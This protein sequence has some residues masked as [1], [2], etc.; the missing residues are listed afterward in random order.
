[1]KKVLL[2]SLIVTLSTLM[3]NAESKSS[4]SANITNFEQIQKIFKKKLRRKCS[5]TSVCL[6]QKHTREEWES[7]KK[8][9]LF[10]EEFEKLCPQGVGILD[11]EM[12]ESLFH[13][14]Y[15]YARGSNTHREL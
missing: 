7:I 12:I 8:S 5:Y 11:D 14:S 10:K 2:F 3:L 4:D 13:F 6:A 9:G 1:M 15:E